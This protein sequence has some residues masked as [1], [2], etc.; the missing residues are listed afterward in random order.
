MVKGVLHPDDAL[1]ARERD[2]DGVIVSNHGGRQVDGAIA[3][4]DALPAVVE[5]AA[6][7]L[8]VLLDSGIRSGSD[9]IKALALGA[10][11]V[12]LGRP[13]LWGLALEGRKRRRDG[14]Q[15]AVRRARPARSLCAAI[16]PRRSSSPARSSVGL[17]KSG[18]QW[19]S[20]AAWAGGRDSS[21]REVIS[22]V[23][24]AASS[25]TSIASSSV[26]A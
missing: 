21:A 12:L 23:P 25:S 6:G 14:A 11:A 1:R 18:A 15:D 19:A 2:I 10:E 3:S 9:V 7:E 20:S 26:R 4:I 17:R 22:S 5:A 16:R 24:R 13:Y 8:V